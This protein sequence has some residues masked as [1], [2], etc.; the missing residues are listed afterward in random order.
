MKILFLDT[1]IFIQCKD[2]KLLPWGEICNNDCLLL[3]IPRAVQEEIDRQKQDGNSRRAKRARKAN[4][5]IRDIILSEETKITIRESNPLVELSFTP[6]EKLNCELPDFLDATR[7]DDRI[8]AEIINY[9][10]INPRKHVAIITHDTNPLLTAKRCKID[11]HIIP[12]EWLLPP[13]P[14]AKDKIIS[15]LEK[16]LKELKNN[17]PVIE[18]LLNDSGNVQNNTISIEVKKYRALSENEKSL[19]VEKLSNTYPIKTDFDQSENPPVDKY[20]GIRSIAGV[21]G[22]SQHFEAP[23]DEEIRKYKNTTYPSWIKNVREY[24]SEFNSKLEDLSRCHT[25]SISISNIGT[26]PAENLIIEFEALGEIYFKSPSKSDESDRQDNQFKMPLPPRPPEGRW[27]NQNNSM[28][29]ILDQIQKAHVTNI[30]PSLF[31]PIPDHL[32]RNKRDRNGI[33]WKHGKSGKPSKSWVFECDE[34]R[35]S[36]EPE[37]FEISIL[38]PPSEITPYSPSI[39]CRVSAKNLPKPVEVFISLDIAFVTYDSYD[40]VMKYIDID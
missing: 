20:T 31:N 35:H 5:L 13:E 36:S 9:K 34:F 10:Q 32:L 19:I 22:Y 39:K 40:E 2:L 1:N 18:I 23:S 25:T 21:F 33:Y 29:G 28:F 3:L 37:E 12:D 17:Y 14:D 6:A 38:I 27:V 30:S 7:P 11:Y 26:I 16:Q 4:S 15:A 8:I 24:L